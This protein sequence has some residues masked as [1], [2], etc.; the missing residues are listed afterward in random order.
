[1]IGR[2]T[3]GADS[4]DP[5]S[6][7]SPVDSEAAAF[8]GW[9]HPHVPAMSR[10][11]RRLV[12]AGD[13]DDVVQDALL[14]AW[15]RRSTFDPQRGSPRSWLLAITGDQARRVRTRSLRDW[16]PYPDQLPSH[17]PR[18]DLDLERAIAR[19]A[20]RQRTAVDLYYFV[21][22]DVAETAQV[23]GIAAGTVQA[24]LHQARARLR[25]ELGVDHD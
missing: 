22:L 19:L 20:E 11:A 25:K 3:R 7:W 4:P 8:T 24:T 17:D 5:A 12:P 23:M 1:M 9:V 13:A 2:P 21:G 15:Q 6:G 14:R 10:Y 18:R 16:V